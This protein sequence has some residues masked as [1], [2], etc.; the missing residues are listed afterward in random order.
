SRVSSFS[1]P[2]Q[3]NLDLPTI[4]EIKLRLNTFGSSNVK[5]RVSRKVPLQG[6]D[7]D[8]HQISLFLFTHNAIT[9]PFKPP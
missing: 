5:E 9:K 3:E 8:G 7:A 2:L 1:S 4:E 6:W